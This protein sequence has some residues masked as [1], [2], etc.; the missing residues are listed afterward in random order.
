MT[1]DWTKAPEW[2]KYHAFDGDGRGGWH[3]HYPIQSV[4][5]YWIAKGYEWPSGYE[6][7]ADV[8]W[9]KTI[10][11]RPIKGESNV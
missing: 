8:Y 7:P 11:A 2:A 5:G 6:K 3:E 4:Y 9:F 10:E 1:I